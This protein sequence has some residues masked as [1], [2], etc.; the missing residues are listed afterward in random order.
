MSKFECKVNKIKQNDS[1]K[2][3]WEYFSF[4]QR[5][6]VKR[7]VFTTLILNFIN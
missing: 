7:D 3:E 1:I 4:Q 2:E 5:Y 6:G